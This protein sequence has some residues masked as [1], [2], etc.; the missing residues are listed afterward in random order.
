[1]ARAKQIFL[2]FGDI[3]VLYAALFCTLFIRFDGNFYNEFAD[4]HALPF[5][6]LFVL[7]LVVFYIAGL[8]DPRRLH[9]NIN[10]FKTLSLSLIVN[11]I[12]GVLFFYMLPVFGI[13]P[14]SNLFLF[15]IIFA[16]LVVFWRRLFNRFIH[17]QAA[18]PFILIGTSPATVAVADMIT[19]N[20]QLG[21]R[22]ESWIRDVSPESLK[23]TIEDWQAYVH[24]HNIK[25]IV[26]PRNFKK[27]SALASFFYGLLTLGVEVQDISGLYQTVFHKIPLAEVAED[28]FLDNITETHKFYDNLKRAGEF[29]FAIILQIVLAPIEL[30]AM[31]LI[32][33]TSPGPIFYSQV[34]VGAHGKTFT[35]YKLR[36]M[37]ADAEKGGAQWAK[38]GD[39]R[40]TPLGA[41]LRKTHIDE[42]PQLWNILR[43]ELSF[44]GP[45]P[46]RPEFVRELR[47]EIPFYETRHLVS[48]G[49]TGWAQVNYRYGASVEDAYEKL[50]YDIFY[51][52]NRSLV[53]DALI[54]LKT[55]K[56]FFFTP[57]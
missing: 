33:V 26:I 4:R 30:L 32:A 54:V 14:K 17:L 36:T 31:V 20:P 39:E 24:A 5:S 49:I 35:L 9:N 23:R 22:I 42:F 34:R 18:A 28:W 7:W 41:F 27:E 56:T 46:E 13:T 38:P 29:V 48:P 10:F 51:I 25:M 44:V 47:E 40:V 8:Y 37:R 43:G 21:Y 55:I 50:S 57:R 11:G 2:I 52:K 45:R 53:M 16:V 15:T 1:M 6:I 12:V 3:I 19:K